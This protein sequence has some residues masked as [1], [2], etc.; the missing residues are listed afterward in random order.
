MPQASR[1]QTIDELCREI[2]SKIEERIS[3]TLDNIALFHRK[4]RVSELT[5]TYSVL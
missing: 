2:F 4:Q 3:L 5:D 1:L